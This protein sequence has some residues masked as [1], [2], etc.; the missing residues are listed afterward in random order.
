[1]TTAQQLVGWTKAGDEGRPRGDFYETPPEATKA[2]LA[3]ENF[4]MQIWEPACG[5]G[6]IS[7]ILE[8]AGHSVYSTDLNDHGYG[9]SRHDFLM[10][11]QTPGGDLVTNPPYT[12]AVEFAQH[13]VKLKIRKIALLARLVFLEGQRRRAFFEASPLKRVWVFSKRLP[14]MHRPGYDGPKSS[15]LIAFA[16]FVWEQGYEG[17]PMIGWL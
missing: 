7:R 16:W 11:W 3:V 12:L 4:A 14:R 5:A 2:L 15:S 17:D 13:A 6:A 8:E 9:E 10:A 1:M